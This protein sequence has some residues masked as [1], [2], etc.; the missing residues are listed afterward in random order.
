[1]SIRCQ[2]SYKMWSSTITTDTLA[3]EDGVFTSIVR[4]LISVVNAKKIL[5]AAKIELAKLF[6]RVY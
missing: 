1:M 6:K 2:K 4:E 5:E 3:L